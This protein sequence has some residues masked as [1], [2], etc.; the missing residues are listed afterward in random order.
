MPCFFCVEA[1]IRE[2]MNAHADD[3]MHN[4]AKAALRDLRCSVQLGVLFTGEVGEAH[5]LAQ[6]EAGGEN[7]WD[8]FLETPG[9]QAAAR[10]ELEA[11]GV[12]MGGGL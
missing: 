5:C 11:L 12:E 6:G 3:Y 10:A 7:H 2:V 1:P 8:K 4:L 9:A